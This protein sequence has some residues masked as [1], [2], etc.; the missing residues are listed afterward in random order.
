MNTNPSYLCSSHGLVV[1]LRYCVRRGAE[2]D[3]EQEFCEDGCSRASCRP[4]RQRL[5]IF[6]GCSWRSAHSGLLCADFPRYLTAQ[7]CFQTC[8]SFVRYKEPWVS[9]EGRL[10]PPGEQRAGGVGWSGGWGSGPSPPG[11]VGWSSGPVV[12]AGA[13]GGAAGRC[14]RV[15]H[16]A[17]GLEGSGRSTLQ[18]FHRLRK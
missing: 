16:R 3:V 2:T 7:R 1:S 17:G 11:G 13:V 8:S 6:S 9:R 4:G 15:E 5:I 10:R 18:V 14:C 12:S